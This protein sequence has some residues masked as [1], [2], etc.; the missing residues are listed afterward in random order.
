VARAGEN[1]VVE[2]NG[3][4]ATQ[5]QL[6]GT[7]STDADGDQLSFEWQGPFGTATGPQPTVL[8]P[9]GRHVIRLIVDDGFGGVSVSEVVIEVVDTT[10]P[11]IR[12]AIPTPS[13]LWPPNHRMVSTTV[14]VDVHDLCDATPSCRIVSVASNEPVNETGDG[15]TPV[16]WEITGALTV[17]LRA[18]RAGNGSGRVYTITIEC[19]D[20]S[21]NASTTDV[22]VTVPHDQRKP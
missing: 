8:L 16:D 21:G 7:A 22:R 18:E 3:H 1:R 10:P 15:N 9:L 14:T 6:D 19:T 17:N 5:V 11:E 12:S 2:C 13:E 20:H 4:D